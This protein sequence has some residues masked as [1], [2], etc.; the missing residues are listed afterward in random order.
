[1]RNIFIKFNLLLLLFLC[2]NCKGGKQDNFTESQDDSTSSTFTG[3]YNR[4][5]NDLNEL[6]MVSAIANGISPMSTRDDT[7]HLEKEL[8]RIPTQLDVYKT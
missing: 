2:V 7:L 4:E 6:H 8:I 5:F 3:D 1:M